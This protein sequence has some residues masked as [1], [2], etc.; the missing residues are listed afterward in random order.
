MD[1][2]KLENILSLK[3]PIC[4][5]KRLKDKV[6]ADKI[7]GSCVLSAFKNA[8]EK[9][10]HLSV[11]NLPCYGAITGCGFVDGIPKT[12]GGYGYFISYGRGE[13]YPEGER[14]KKCP[15][16]AEEMILS[17]PQGVMN[18]YKTIQIGS[19]TK[20]DDFDTA[21]FIV[22][23][24]QLSALV[25]LFNFRRTAYD[26]IISPMC[27]GC[28]SVFRI[29]FGVTEF[30]VSKAVIGNFDIGARLDFDKDL[31]FFSVVKSDFEQMLSDADESIFTTSYWMKIKRRLEESRNV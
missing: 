8:A 20:G 15:E 3:Y 9:K 23:P 10:V 22:N 12:P 27:S 4:T 14:V 5:V 11:D 2:K 18:G 16:L 24:D 25:H 21:V 31:L 13:G 17:Q 19:Y 26:T 28:A 29:P 6:N 1:I 30:P 7:E